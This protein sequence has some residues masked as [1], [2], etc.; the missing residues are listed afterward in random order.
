[1]TSPTTS[2]TVHPI[3][4]RV[5]VLV[6]DAGADVRITVDHAQRL[7]DDIDATVTSGLHH[8]S[9][10]VSIS[11]RLTLELATADARHLGIRLR[12]A[13]AVSAST[14][15]VDTYD[16]LIAAADTLITDGACASDIVARVWAAGYLAGT[17]TQQTPAA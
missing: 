9:I 12:D 10:A 6:H 14:N 15:T 3:D 1:M 2:I 16:A 4:G 5:A 8:G 13:A 17:L 7:A 11:R